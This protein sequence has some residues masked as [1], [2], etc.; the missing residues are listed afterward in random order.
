MTCKTTPHN[1]EIRGLRLTVSDEVTMATGKR[2]EN[3]F[4]YST[5][6]SPEESDGL[7]S[8]SYGLCVSLVT[9][10]PAFEGLPHATHK[11]CQT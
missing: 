11:P 6:L 3:G 7:A 2:R 8:C 10:S 1:G 5:S 4:T 9:T